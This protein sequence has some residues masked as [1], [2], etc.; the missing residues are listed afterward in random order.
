MELHP[1][2]SERLDDLAEL[3]GTTVVTTRCHCTWFLLRDPERNQVWEAGRSRE[4]FERFTVEAPAPTGVLAYS[5]G[6]AVGWCAVGARSWYPRLEISKMWRGGD[7]DAWVVT[8]FYVRRTARRSG[9]TANLLDAAAALAA[10]QG[11]KVVE[12]LPRASGINTSSGDGYVGFESTFLACGFT[13]V[14][15]PNGKR[16]LMRRTVG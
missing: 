8:C 14:D 1:I 9:L 4:C 15:R 11:A 2:T 5:G 7:P 6:A 10:E 12:G 3:F 13:A 16:V